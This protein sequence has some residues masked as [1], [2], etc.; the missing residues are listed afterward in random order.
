[1]AKCKP[2]ASVKGSFDGKR[3]NLRVASFDGEMLQALQDM[4][5]TKSNAEH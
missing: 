3:P 1:M 4:N 5:L 2:A